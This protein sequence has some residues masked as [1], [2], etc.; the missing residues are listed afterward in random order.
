MQTRLDHLIKSLLLINFEVK[1]FPTVE[2]PK[3]FYLLLDFP[4]EDLEK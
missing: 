1:M 2:D 4:Q 3:I